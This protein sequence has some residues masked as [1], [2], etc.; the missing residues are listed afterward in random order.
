MQRGPED[1]LDKPIKYTT[2]TGLLLERFSHD[3]HCKEIYGVGQT[4]QIDTTSDLGRIRFALIQF[5]NGNL[6]SEYAFDL[7]F[8]R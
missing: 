4:C 1:I 6:D 7:P 5:Q 2:V 8:S 3:C